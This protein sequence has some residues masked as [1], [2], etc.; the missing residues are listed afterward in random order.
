MRIYFTLIRY[1]L[2]SLYPWNCVTCV[3]V[4][5]TSTKND[6]YR[7]ERFKVCLSVCLS[8]WSGLVW[9]GLYLL[10]SRVSVLV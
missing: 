4:T 9:S 1:L 6:S 8:V 7:L 3:T 5:V 2:Y 10:S